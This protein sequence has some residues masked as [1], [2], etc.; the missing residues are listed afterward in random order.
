ML[1]SLLSCSGRLCCKSMIRLSIIEIWLAGL[2]AAPAQTL[3]HAVSVASTQQSTTKLLLKLWM[4][5]S[6]KIWLHWRLQ[7][8]CWRFVRGTSAM[9]GQLVDSMA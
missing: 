3:M 1:P 7:V 2:E 9:P 6:R 8:R 4:Y 5:V